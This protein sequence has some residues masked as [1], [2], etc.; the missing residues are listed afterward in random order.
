M[1]ADRQGA[2]CR[3]G[4]DLSVITYGAMLR[5]ALSAAERLAADGIE[6]DVLDLRSLKP[7]VQRRSWPR[8]AGQAR[9]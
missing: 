5:E 4:D 8:H 9:C 3:E 7:L 1:R 2:R 6:T